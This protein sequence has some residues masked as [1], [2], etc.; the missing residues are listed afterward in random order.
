MLHTEHVYSIL[1]F[2]H[3]QSRFY[4]FLTTLTFNYTAFYIGLVLGELE[5]LLHRSRVMRVAQ[6]ARSDNFYFYAIS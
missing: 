3:L 4:S 6:H 1:R 5:S 2:L